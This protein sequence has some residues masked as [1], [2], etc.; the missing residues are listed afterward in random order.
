MCCL[1]VLFVTTHQEGR[2]EGEEPEV[3]LLRLSKLAGHALWTKFTLVCILEVSC[4]YIVH[5]GSCL[6]IVQGDSGLMAGSLLT[7]QLLGMFDFGA[8]AW[9]LGCHRTDPGSILGMLIFILSIHGVTK[10]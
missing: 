9:I 8:V 7:T 5:G 2:R 4:R 6:V 10:M 3:P 1:F